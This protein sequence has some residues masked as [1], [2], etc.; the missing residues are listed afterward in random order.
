MDGKQLAVFSSS[1]I[2]GICDF[3][4][5][6]WRIIPLQYV[7]KAKFL[8]SSF[9]LV[10]SNE[11]LFLVATDLTELKPS[12]IPL[13]GS[14]SDVRFVDTFG[15]D[16]MI[17]QMG[18]AV[19]VFRFN[20]NTETKQIHFTVVLNLAFEQLLLQ[21]A[22]LPDG[23]L[24]LLT[25]NYQLLVLKGQE[26][27]RL[28]SD[29]LQF[30]VLAGDFIILKKPER[31]W[32]LHWKGREYPLKSSFDALYPHLTGI[33]LL[34]QSDNKF[35]LNASAPETSFLLPELFFLTRQQR[36]LDEFGKEKNDLL[37][38]CL[39]YLILKCANE[40]ESLR[41]L[42]EYYREYASFEFAKALTNVARKI[43]VHEASGLLA[44]MF[45]FAPLKIIQKLLD[46]DE[47]EA[48]LIFIPYLAKSY[49]EDIPGRKQAIKLVLARLR[50]VN[51]PKLDAILEFLTELQ[52]EIEA[53]D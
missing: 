26:L 32:T 33:V 21:S 38:L 48:P 3:K 42:D 52:L 46:V 30:L 7:L 9:L 36:L 14:T 22:L 37:S 41:I 25:A 51:H 15:G 8:G 2:I 10:L 19:H 53:L 29:C 43:E 24:L 5:R 39:Q 12:V 16:Q 28:S 44:H 18:E 45:H 4:K 34:Q 47:V 20:V 35:S 23:N 40:P 1:G 17:I 49:H 27:H 31:V 13:Q 6:I 50:Q 11:G